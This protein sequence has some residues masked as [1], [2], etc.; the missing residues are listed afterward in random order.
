MNNT[1]II[2]IIDE[3]GVDD[4]SNQNDFRVQSHSPHENTKATDSP[5]AF[6]PMGLL[7]QP[8]LFVVYLLTLSIYIYLWLNSEFA[9]DKTSFYLTLLF[10]VRRNFPIINFMMELKRLKPMIM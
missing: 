1:V 3:A 5:T 9:A 8:K 2:T 6:L 4:D 7:P 10:K